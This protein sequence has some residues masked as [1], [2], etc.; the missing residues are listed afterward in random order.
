LV[1]RQIEKVLDDVECH[2]AHHF[3]AI[4]HR[5]S[6]RRAHDFHHPLHELRVAERFLELRLLWNNLEY[7]ELDE[8]LFQGLNGRADHV[9]H[10]YEKFA[11]DDGVD[12]D[13]TVLEQFEG[14]QCAPGFAAAR[15]ILA[16]LAE[17][18]HRHLR[19]R[20]RW[21]FRRNGRHDLFHRLALGIK[22]HLAQNIQGYFKVVA[23]QE[24]SLPP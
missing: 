2:S 18:L 8:L 22:V 7:F 24:T 15:V 14:L 12:A 11:F 5:L 13:V 17:Q 4:R 1:L 20:Q 19:R 9:C 16:Y 21:I 23:V 10:F 6:C 3:D